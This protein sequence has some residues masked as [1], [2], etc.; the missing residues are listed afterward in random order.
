MKKS[1]T[2]VKITKALLAVQKKLEPVKKEAEN[3]FFKSKY[4]DLSSLI[5][6]CKPIL[7]KN[8][9]VALQPISGEFVETVLI[10]ESGEWISSE[11]KIVMKMVTRT[12]TDPRNPNT[13]V[14]TEN[15]P[16]A[17]GSAV[18]YARRYGLQSMLFMSSED[19]DAETATGRSTTAYKTTSQEDLMKQFKMDTKQVAPKCPACGSAMFLVKRKDGS[20][21]FWSC[22]NWKT[23]GCQ[24]LNV[25]NVDID[26]K[27]TEKKATKK[28]V[29]G[30]D[31][32][33]AIDDIPF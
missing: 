16:Q 32:V 24:G 11:T 14:K 28:T 29:R 25:D 22:Q 33:A 17:Y 20:G 4:A 12:E 27:I 18:S 31:E 26:G 3:P 2:I 19:D 6:A 1:E 10:H 5:E 8:K 30:D 9:I 21:I 7:T 23:K 13:V 15:D